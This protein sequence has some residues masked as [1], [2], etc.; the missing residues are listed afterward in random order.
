MIG[1]GEDRDSLHDNAS[2]VCLR[3]LPTE[4]EDRVAQAGPSTSIEL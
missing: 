1:R 3:E 2:R 4:V